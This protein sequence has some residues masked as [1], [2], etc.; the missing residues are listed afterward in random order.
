[1]SAERFSF[2]FNV[3]FG[4]CSSLWLLNS[5][6]EYKLSIASETYKIYYV[7]ETYCSKLTGYKQKSGSEYFTNKKKIER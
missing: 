3:D 2:I 6:L 4:A 1:M 7:A 5:H